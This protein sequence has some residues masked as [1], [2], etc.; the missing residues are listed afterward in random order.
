VGQQ[1]RMSSSI[2]GKRQLPASRFD[3]STY[4]GRV[5]HSAEI[6]DPRAL[7]LSSEGLSRAIDVIKEYKA[8][9]RQL[10][11]E[12]WKAKNAVDATIHP[13]TGEKVFLPWRMSCFVLTNLVVTAG[14]LTPGLTTLG[15]VGWQI[16]NQSVNVAINYSN[17][18]KTLPLSTQ[19]VALSY[20][21]AVSASCG[22]A[23]GANRIV[24]RMPLGA[25]AKETLGRLV[26][27]LAVATAG[28]LNVFL[29]RGNE[30]QRG[31]EITGQD[32]EKL[33]L[34]KKAAWLAVG[35]T[36]ASRVLN[37]TP[38]MVVPALALVALQRRGLPRR[39]VLATN[40]GLIL[41]TSLVALPFA[42]GV[43]PQR[44]TVDGNR[45]EEA[46]HGNGP[47]QFNRGM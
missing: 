42:L 18:N 27:F 31:I 16:T 3:L 21:L 45:L 9:K 10:T 2:P 38:V 35:E 23:I 40:L 26:P 29:M 6:S 13:D 4:V 37:A 1:D 14:M 32:G 28:L 41:S 24:P 36:G 22:V 17:A 33:G 12:V 43:F 39:W 19:Q 20:L 15:T 25:G 11:P 30:I 46:F 47:V 7:L 8:G 34:S 44:Q 5:K